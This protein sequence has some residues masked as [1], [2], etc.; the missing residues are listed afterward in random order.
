MQG[1]V[2]RGRK[3]WTPRA[4]GSHGPRFA[5]RVRSTIAR[6]VKVGNLR[7][8]QNFVAGN[9]LR[10]R[11]IETDAMEPQRAVRRRIP[12]MVAFAVLIAA[13]ALTGQGQRHTRPAEKQVSGPFRVGEQLDYRV[14]W[15]SFLSAATVQLSVPERRNLYGWDTF[16]LRAIAHT[17][18]PVRALFAIDDQF[19][20][21]SDA[22]PL[23]SRQYETHLNEMG[24]RDDS[25]IRMVARGESS[26]GDGPSVIVLPGTRDPI[27]AF[28]FL[29]EVDWQ[30]TPEITCPVYDGRTLY[31]MYAHLDLARES[32]TVSAGSFTATRIAVSLIARGQDSPRATA[33]IWIGQDPARTPFVIEAELPI[34][35]LRA[36]LTAATK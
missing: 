31:Q 10:S 22:G 13:G 5:Y 27:S 15:K 11:R 4:S 21:Y 14:G 24:K 16:H 32:V 2:R 30:K 34:G 19:D 6:A 25:V 9:A 18:S 26:H 28:Y 17:L 35:T 36:E 20:S 7:N 1:C 23:A 29:R 3:I 12:A 33:T 8:G